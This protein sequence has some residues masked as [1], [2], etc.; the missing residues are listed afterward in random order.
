M[1]NVLNGIVILVIAVFAI[2]VGIDKMKNKK[3]ASPETNQSMPNNKKASDEYKTEYVQDFMDFEKIYKDMIIRDKGT[4]FTMVI[5][6]SGINFDLMS[7]NERT[8]VEEAF[9]ELLNFI[10]FPIQ[11]YVQTRKVDLKDSLKIYGSKVT[12]IENQLRLLVD[13]YN[14]LKTEKS[15][16]KDELSIIAY[17][18][19]RKT[20]LYEYAVDL[21]K[22][23]ERLSI[24]SNVLQYRYYIAITYHIEEL[25][26]MTNFTENEITEMA[27]SELYTRSHSII[28]ALVSCDIVAKA[29][30]SNSLAELLYMGFNRD[31]G[32][33]FRLKDNM[34]AGFYRLYSTTETIMG[35]EIEEYED[36]QDG[37]Q[38]QFLTI[39]D[40]FE[41][42]EYSKEILQESADE[43]ISA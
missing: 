12:A 23:I 7:E 43:S 34:E 3:S 41:L 1:F 28:N 11:L 33:L 6:C 32:E 20:N 35:P 29:M 4:K 22:Y 17:E 31:D 18:I 21:K 9:I 5:H 24:N 16:D 13:K 14:T 8:M 40:N 38:A 30:D 27:Y 26:L 37:M 19:E 39:D 10:Q 42:D 2:I 36:E 25:G 15:S